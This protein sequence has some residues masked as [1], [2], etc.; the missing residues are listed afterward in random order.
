MWS[1]F[2]RGVAVTI[3]GIKGLLFSS[4]DRVPESTLVNPSWHGEPH[5]EVGVGGEQLQAKEI[6]RTAVSSAETS[7]ESS[8]GLPFESLGSVSSAFVFPKQS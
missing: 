6:S 5:V 8:F 3:V 4:P 1:W 2:S 7:V